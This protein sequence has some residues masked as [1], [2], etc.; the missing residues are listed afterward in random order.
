M[1][2]VYCKPVKPRSAD[3]NENVLSGVARNYF[4]LS[5]DL[6]KGVQPLE[7]VL[8]E[9]RMRLHNNRNARRDQVQGKL[10]LEQSAH[11]CSSV[12]ASASSACYFFLSDRCLLTTSLS[13]G[14][15]GYSSR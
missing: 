4:G 13:I 1:V 9:V 6:I 2:A 12:S 3:V 7:N 14:S 5:D 8:E 10:D 15:I 11:A